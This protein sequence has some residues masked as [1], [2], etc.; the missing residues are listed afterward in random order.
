[1]IYFIFRLGIL[2]SDTTYFS[3][4][5]ITDSTSLNSL[6]NYIP[7]FDVPNKEYHFNIIDDHIDN[8]WPNERVADITN[9]STII[10]H[11]VTNNI[12]S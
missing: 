3:A 5:M 11:S 10:Y 9:V 12:S 1:M 8:S 4:D 7:T 2:D 6:T